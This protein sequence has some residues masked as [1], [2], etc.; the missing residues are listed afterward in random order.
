MLPFFTDVQNLESIT[1]GWMSFFM[2]MPKPI[3]MCVGALIDYKLRVLGIPLRWRSEITAWQP[4][5]RFVDEQR[6]ELYCQWI[7]EQTFEAHKDGTICRDSIR[8]A[9]LGGR[10]IERLFVRNDVKTILDFPQK[11]LGEIFW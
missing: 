2:V 7:H 10:I 5:F 6:R 9:V 8:Y 11:K 4:P 1:P 3:E